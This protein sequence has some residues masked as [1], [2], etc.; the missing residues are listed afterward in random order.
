LS[1]AGTALSGSCADVVKSNPF[2]L[3]SWGEIIFGSGRHEEIHF[4]ELGW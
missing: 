3:D 4:R 1:G 2:L